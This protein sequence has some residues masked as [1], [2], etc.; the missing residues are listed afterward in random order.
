MF[1]ADVFLRM[2]QRF[3]KRKF[4]CALRPRREGRGITRCR[5]RRPDCLL[6]LAPDG[7]KGDAKRCKRLCPK[8][9]S[10]LDETQKKMF[11]TDEALVQGAGLLLGEDQHP[12]S[13]GL[14][15]LEHAAMVCA[16]GRPRLPPCPF[17]VRHPGAM[18]AHPL[19]RCEISEL[20]DRLHGLLDM[21][22]VDEMTATTG[23]TYRLQGAVVALDAVLGS[24]GLMPSTPEAAG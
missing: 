18:A 13:L 11:G 24:L 22:A 9:I 2:V 20:A 14:E 15:P 7:L 12:A 4:E 1:R 17:A 3:A 19:T 5:P 21:I 16:S 23:M 10:F 8:T 6:D